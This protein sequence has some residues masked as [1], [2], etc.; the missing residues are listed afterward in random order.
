MNRVLPL[1]SD[2][3]SAG[4]PLSWFGIAEFLRPSFG[5]ILLVTAS[6][7][8]AWGPARGDFLC[9]GKVD[10]GSPRGKPGVRTTGTLNALV[11]FAKF[12]GEAPGN[13]Q[14]PSWAPDLF[15]RQMPGSF[16]HFY[17]EMSRGQLQ[18]DGQV[19]PR[20]YSSRRPASAFLAPE[21]GLRGRFGQFNLE[22]LEQVDLDVDLGRFDN[23]GADGVPNSGDDDGY[24]DVV[25]INLLTVPENFFVSRATG[26]AS[27]GLEADFISDD[28]AAA[29]GWIRI[30]SRFTGFGGTTQRGHVFSVTAATMCH[31]FG[32]ILGLPDLFDQTSIYAGTELDPAEDSAGIGKWG[33]MG[34]GTLGWGEGDGPNA[35]CAWSLA[36]LGWI[37]VG[38]EHLIEVEQS[39]IGAVFDDIDSG[40]KVYKI[41]V[42]A[43]EYFLLENRQ[44]SSSF[45]NRN[46][47]AGGILV[48]HVDDGADNDE[49]RHKQVDLVCAD[50]LYAD[51]GFPAIRPDPVWG[52]DNLDFWS[53]DEAYATA[54]N[55]NQGDA[56]DPFDGVARTRFA[57][58]TNPGFSAHAGLSRN[59]PLGF[60]VENIRA[61]GTRLTADILVGQ[62][63]DGHVHADTTWSGEVIV[64]GDVVVQPGATLTVAPGTTVRIPGGDRRRTGFYPERSE[65]LVFGGLVLQG[66]TE[67]PLSFVSG[68]ASPRSGDWAGV[69]LMNAQDPDLREVHIE[70]ATHGVV[71]SHLPP[72]STRWS[73]TRTLPRDL[74]VPAGSELVIEAGARVDFASTDL[75]AG[76]RSP[77]LTELIVEGRLRVEG[78]DAQAVR[79]DLASGN[80]DSV[81]FGVRLRPGAQVEIR[82]L[83]EEQCVIGFS[84]EV[85]EAGALSIADSRIANTAG[86][87]LRLAINGTVEVDRTLFRG[88]PLQG[89]FAEGSG[90]LLL[91]NSTVRENGQEG[92]FLG[93]CSLEAIRTTVEEN[94]LLQAEDPRSGLRAVGGRGQKIELWNCA[95]G[96]NTLHGLDLGSWEGVL[97]LHRSEVSANRGN[98]LELTAL[99]RVIFE[100]VKVRRNLGS[101]VES[102]AAP[103]EIWTTEFVD[104]I[105]PGLILAEGTTGAI[106]MCHF[107]NNTGLRLESVGE[108][109]VRTSTFENTALGLASLNSAPRLF[110]NRFSNNLKAIEAS[111]TMVPAEIA[112]NVFVDNRTAIDN[113][114]N[115]TLVARDNYW[116]TVDTTAI[117]AL[118]SGAVEW[119][120]FLEEDPG[121]IDI[122]DEVGAQ[123]AQ[124]ALHAGFPN[125]FHGQTTIRFDIA[126]PVPAELVVYNLGGQPVR[127]LLRRDLQS[128]SYAGVWDGRGDNGRKVA[129]GVYLYRLRAGSFSASGRVLVLR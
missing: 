67:D 120:P 15:N 43:E 9:A 37:G 71:R 25:F 26:F 21:A 57:H 122:A 30:P 1:R 82:H 80:P 16:A 109:F 121:E 54:H 18:V 51:R 91:R 24:V 101:G 106:E 107:R 4:F 13:D 61:Q 45:Y 88:H 96:R 11:I 5:S 70:N 111:G 41:P 93:N 63:L 95:V 40:G 81:W 85:T 100:D 10:S 6:L 79:F 27:L 108:L 36:Q 19:L 44:N 126:A 50:G 31:E 42:G 76:G 123:P 47:P 38:N 49:E 60:A 73:G 14:A 33:L 34:L 28:P 97:E 64:D 53:R 119:A 39:L 55:G 68:A 8:G 2:A 117:A 59:L 78:S 56:G 113:R 17:E 87:G 12:Q 77:Q 86:N 7:L 48:W 104:N 129:S 94:G 20:R 127:R 99:E 89:I 75:G 23:D 72:G 118:F 52:R 114:T 98:G 83:Q 112:R 128:G 105:G 84:G 124:F 125:P 69:F 90:R 66:S 35:F 74:V 29:G 116:G 115:L 46:I 110:G 102:K 103:V 32:H 58:D 3:E 62:P 65:L 22:I 92:I